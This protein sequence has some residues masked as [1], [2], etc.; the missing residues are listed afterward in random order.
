MVSRRIHTSDSERHNWQ[1]DNSNC[2]L[3]LMT[4]AAG[5]EP[6]LELLELDES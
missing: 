4:A 1:K 3:V 2:S 5:S 6:D